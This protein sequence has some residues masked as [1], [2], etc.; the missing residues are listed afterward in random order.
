MAS[1]LARV[2]DFIPA[3]PIL[4]GEV[5]SE[6]N[7]I[8]NLLNGTS[9]NIKATL[10]VSDAGDPPL[11]LNQLSTGPIQEWYQA[12]ILKAQ[13]ANDGGLRLTGG[14]ILV[15]KSAPVLQLTDSGLSKNWVL[16]V[17]GLGQLVIGESGISNAIIIDDV[18][19][20]PTFE[21]IPIGPAS[22]PTTANQLTRKSYVDAKKVSFTASFSIADPSTATLSDPA[23]GSII[24][25]AGGQ[26]T[27][28]AA[29][30]AYVSGSHTA[31]G[32]VTFIVQQQGVGTI[33]SL[34]LNDTNNA[35]NTV[36]PDNFADFNVSENAIFCV[37]VS[38]RSGTVSERNVTV[39]IEGYRLT[40]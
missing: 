24:I 29:K 10:D 39:T 32:S 6:F 23:F 18:T 5:D 21:E 19:G 37:F 34:G 26:Y 31:G 35:S 36:Y 2:T 27:I 17:N 16:F 9:I 40:F 12:G 33:S 4:S 13:V 11:E 7:Q 1:T 8:V 30:V 25:P 20:V 28:T 3:T 14:D 22:D 15:S 38:A